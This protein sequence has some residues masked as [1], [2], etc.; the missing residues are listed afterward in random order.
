MVNVIASDSMDYYV[1]N[2]S[3]GVSLTN[4]TYNIKISNM[5]KFTGVYNINISESYWHM[6][7]SREFSTYM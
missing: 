3:A 1:S 6:S 5:I 7:N 4:I 2:P